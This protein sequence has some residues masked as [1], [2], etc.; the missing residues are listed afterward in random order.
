MSKKQCIISQPVNSA[1]KK[2]KLIFKPTIKGLVIGLGL[3]DIKFEQIKNNS[4]KVIEMNTY[5]EFRE[6]FG[7]EQL[8][9]LL[10]NCFINFINY[11]LINNNLNQL[12]SDPY[13]FNKFLLR[14][15]LIQQLTNKDFDIENLFYPPPELQIKNPK[16]N[17][18]PIVQQPVKKLLFKIRDNLGK[19]IDLL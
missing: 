3:L 16:N 12:L 15:I 17:V 7:V 6:N 4:E 19:T 11:D 13:S 1:K 2:S 10:K 8:N 5:R 9:S 14:G 18:P